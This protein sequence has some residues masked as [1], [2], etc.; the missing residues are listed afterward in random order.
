MFPHC[1]F[2]ALFT[3]IKGGVDISEFFCQS[4]FTWNQVWF[5]SKIWFHG[6]FLLKHFCIT[7]C[8]LLLTHFFTFYNSG[9]FTADE[10]LFVTKT[11]REILFDGYDDPLLHMLDDVKALGFKIP[12]E[13]PSKF[14]FYFGKNDTWY[15]NGIGKCHFLPFSA[16]LAICSHLLTI[17]GQ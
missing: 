15:G 14:G 6:I 4:G 2:L 17:I 9:L 16:I 7:C 3:F 12:G 11:A 5:H 13:L 8:Y 1:T 10:K